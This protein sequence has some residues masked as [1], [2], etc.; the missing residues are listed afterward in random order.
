MIGFAIGGVFVRAKARGSCRRFRCDRK[1]HSEFRSPRL[2]H[3]VNVSLDS[4]YELARDWKAEA[5]SLADRL[6]REKLLKD[7]LAEVRWD[8]GTV[9]DHPHDHKLELPS[10]GDL[11]VAPFGRCVDRIVD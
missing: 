11:H 9:I 4:V 10:G 1:A 3:D 6:G 8:F 2:R 7:P 5:G